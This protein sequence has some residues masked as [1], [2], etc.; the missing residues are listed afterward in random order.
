MVMRVFFCAI[1][2]AVM[3]AGAL[4][5]LAGCVNGEPTAAEESAVKA[6]T[7][8][9]ESDCDAHRADVRSLIQASKSCS[10]D[11]DCALFSPGCPFGCVDAVRVSQISGIKAAYRDY[12]RSCGACAYM[13]PQPASERRAACEKSE[14]V[15]REMSAQPLIRN[16]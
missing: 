7:Q 3:V 16:K 13:C 15:V 6:D 4:C 14:C 9:P 11:K 5:V 2:P 1:V 12:A 8:G 10:V